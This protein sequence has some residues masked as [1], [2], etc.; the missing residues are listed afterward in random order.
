MVLDLASKNCCIL[1]DT[2]SRQSHNR[3]G[4]VA[5][6]FMARLAKKGDMNSLSNVSMLIMGFAVHQLSF[7]DQSQVTIDGQA[8]FLMICVAKWLCSMLGT[9][10]SEP[11][12]RSS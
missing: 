12:T 9:V 1:I 11:S 3:P 2:G 8:T 10:L 5:T 7:F 6:P 4:N